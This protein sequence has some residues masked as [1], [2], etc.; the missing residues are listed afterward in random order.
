MDIQIEENPTS[1]G[2]FSLSDQ[3]RFW[4][5]RSPVN[6][7]AAYR[8]RRIARRGNR[9]IPLKSV[10]YTAIILLVP[11]GWAAGVPLDVGLLPIVGAK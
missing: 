10:L 6:G 4:R 7:R 1:D 3:A 5:G 11:L 9:K 8:I 2:G